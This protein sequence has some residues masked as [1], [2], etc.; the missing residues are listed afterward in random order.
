VTPVADDASAAAIVE[1]VVRLGH[2]LGLVVVAEGVETA[3]QLSTLRDLG[4]DLAQGYYLARPAPAP[5]ILPILRRPAAP[6]QARE[7]LDL[8]LDLD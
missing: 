4:C 1:S 3:D 6:I 2:A 5:S 8:R 7:D